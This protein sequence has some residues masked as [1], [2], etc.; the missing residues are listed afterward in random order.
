M[1]FALSTGA[2]GWDLSGSIYTPQ[3]LTYSTAFPATE[4]PISQSAR[5]QNGL[6]YGGSW[7]DVQTTAGKAFGT[8]S[9]TIGPPYNDSAA[10]LL[11]ASGQLWGADQTVVGRVFI[12]SRVGWSSFKEVECLLRGTMIP[13]NQAFTGSPNT[14]QMYEVLF[15]VIA[16]TTYISMVRW[17]G[18]LNAFTEIARKDDWAGL[19]SG[20]YVRGRVIGFTMEAATSPDGL[21]WTTLLSHDIRFDLLGN[22]TNYYTDG[23]P[24]MGF[25]NRDPTAGANSTFGFDQLDIAA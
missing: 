15:S 1:G 14:L 4:N 10:L 3:A 20:T 7:S 8:Q 5:W 21:D 24:G 12:T 19:S 22:P 18:R 13:S 16:G 2:V 11:P 17:D 25:W 9:G 23:Y 6:T